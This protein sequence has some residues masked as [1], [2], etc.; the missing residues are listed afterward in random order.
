MEWTEKF[1]EQHN[2]K[3]W[4]NTVT[5]ESSWIE[6]P[7]PAGI[8]LTST[9]QTTVNKSSAA[10]V[11]WIE[12]YS[13]QHKRKYW[14][15]SITNQTTWTEPEKTT[16]N[17]TQ[18]V[19]AINQ[20]ID[21]TWI[22]KYSE[23][24]KRKYW[25]NSKTG[26]TSWTEPEKSTAS[27]VNQKTNNEE[28][29]EKYSEQ[30]KRKYWR[31]S[32]TGKTSWTPPTIAIEPKKSESNTSAI[33]TSEWVE[34]YSQQHN[35]KYWKN[36]VTGKTTWANP[37]PSLSTVAASSTNEA[38]DQNIQLNQRISELE[39]Q[40]KNLL[41]QIETFRLSDVASKE[42]LAVEEER[43]KLLEKTIE[44]TASDL[45]KSEEIREQLAVQ[46]QISSND[47]VLYKRLYEET[48]KNILHKLDERHQ[49]IDSIDY[50][51]ES[52]VSVQSALQ[53]Q[54]VEDS[55]NNL[56]RVTTQEFQHHLMDQKTAHEA[57]VVNLSSRL[58]DLQ[59]KYDSVVDDRQALTREL[60]LARVH[61][62]ES[63]LACQRMQI[64]M[65]RHEDLLTRYTDMAS[66][67][68]NSNSHNNEYEK[69]LAQ[70]VQQLQ[71]VQ[72]RL[73]STESL[74]ISTVGGVGR[75]D[76]DSDATSALLKE[77]H[78]M[79]INL[80]NVYD[81]VPRDPPPARYLDIEEFLE[82]PPPESDDDMP[83]PDDI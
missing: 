7:K 48:E 28:W 76:N 1:S 45:R 65:K 41:S 67:K 11:E 4:K 44:T 72:E 15:N 61:L 8:T 58:S 83:P 57:V 71:S 16:P 19:N 17:I 12:K 79:L 43:V 13:E 52:K 81:D 70:A 54:Q 37:S 68:E 78:S 25:Q 30:H 10:N 31:N 64:D 24:H 47:A 42:K 26:Q 38:G 63:E 39:E 3:Y 59:H 62:R 22:E 23:K 33:S 73:T 53:Q 51:I 14:K 20:S 35:K 5:G 69:K 34:K 56:T 46:L 50:K 29:Q 6:P 75:S 55:L 77:V 82:S 80:N 74:T 27:M 66:L 21:E 36:S 49:L 40:S 2:R 60:E 32:V 9:S 18:G